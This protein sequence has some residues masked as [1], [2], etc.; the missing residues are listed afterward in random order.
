MADATQ[1]RS[2][3]LE[4]IIRKIAKS[5]LFKQ[6][7]QSRIKGTFILFVQTRHEFLAFRYPNRINE[8]EEF[9]G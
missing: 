3:Q 9:L 6:R 7:F 4:V 2:Q 1:L 8:I 5:H